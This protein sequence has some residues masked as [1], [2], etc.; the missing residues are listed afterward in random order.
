MI[1]LVAARTYERQ[2]RRLLTPSERARGEGE[3]ASAP[4]AWPLIVGTG[5]ARK[6]RVAR[7]SRGK[8]GGARII[9]YHASAHGVVT[10]L[11][12]YAKNEKE[13]LTDADRK[14]LR[15]VIEAIRAELEG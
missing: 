5:G 12:I 2:V 15:E 14:D 4:D 3:I 8:S 7:G 9:Y 10:L 1:R 6:A 13:D 11:A